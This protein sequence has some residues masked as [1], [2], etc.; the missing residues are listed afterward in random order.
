MTDTRRYRD[1]E[2]RIEHRALFLWD[3]TYYPRMGT[4]FRVSGMTRGLY[5]DADIACRRAIDVL[6]A[7]SHRQWLLRKARLR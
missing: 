2:Y 1:I 4:P 5:R 3:W 7:E 6:C